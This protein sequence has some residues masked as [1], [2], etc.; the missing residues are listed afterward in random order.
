MTTLL[1]QQPARVQAVLNILVESPY[2]YKSDHEE[3]FYF[4]R[5]HQ[6]EFASFFKEHFNWDLTLD[7]KCARLYKPDWFNPRITPVNRDMFNFTKRDECIGFMLLLE[8]FEHRLEEESASVD[9]AENLR[10]RF[11]DFLRYAHG[12]FIELFPG[13]IEAYSEDAVRSRAL[14]PIMP[15]LEKYRFLERIDPPTDETVAY[16]DMIFEAL[17]ALW[18]YNVH[19][20][21]RPIVEGEAQPARVPGAPGPDLQAGTEQS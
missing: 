18:H 8:F 3:L 21:S 1:Q 13:Q 5:R 12:R 4:L 17:P 11:G 15:Q 19:R 10:F 7:G 6:K 16:D 9:D 14:R 2:F 20:L